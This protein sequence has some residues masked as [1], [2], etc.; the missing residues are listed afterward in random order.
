MGRR[1]DGERREIS[2]RRKGGKE[3]VRWQGELGREGAKEG[4]GPYGGR[5]RKPEKSGNGG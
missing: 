1:G 5:K 3:A 4:K 2:G